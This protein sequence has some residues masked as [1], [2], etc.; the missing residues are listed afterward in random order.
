MYNIRFCHQ[1]YRNNFSRMSDICKIYRA[2]IILIHP[3]SQIR[4]RALKLGRR[5]IKQ[6][7]KKSSSFY[8]RGLKVFLLQSLRNESRDI[9]VLI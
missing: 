2:K 8:N 4:C 9:Y 3:R 1:Y 7:N 6:Y 5:N